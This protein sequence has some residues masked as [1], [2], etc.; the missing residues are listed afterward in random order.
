MNKI[1]VD[2]NSITGLI[3][4]MHGV[5]QPPMTGITCSLF[6]YLKEAG[7]PYS[8]LH[9]T[10]G[11]MGS[12]LYVDIP[13]IFRDFDADENDPN[14]YSFAFTDKIIEGLM[15]NKCEPFFRLGVTIENYWE[16]QS[17]RVFPPADFK[18]WARVCEHI[19]RHYNEGWANGYRYG[20]TYW[21]IWNE[22]EG[23]ACWRGTQEEYFRLYEI[24]S[25]HLKNCFGDSIKVGGYASCGFYAI[26]KNPDINNIG[27]D[28][29]VPTEWYLKYFYDFLKYITSEEHKSPL[30][31]F[32][33]HTYA[34]VHD[35][36]KYAEYSHKILC[37]YG[38][39]NIEEIIDEWNPCHDMIKKKTGYAAAQNLAMLLAMQK[40]SVSMMN[41]YDAR[42]GYS[43]FSGMFNPDTGTP[44][45]TY[46]AFMSFNRLY[47]LKNEVKTYSDNDNIF[48]GAATD[49]N[50]KVILLSNINDKAMTVEFDIKGAEVKDEDIF[51]I[52]EE[53]VYSRTGKHIT[54]KKLEIPA[55][56]CVEI[57]F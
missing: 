37:D 42:I 53:Y 27:L 10:G 32:S 45:P 26:D 51:M 11:A 18:K 57:S 15:E 17:F 1:S 4:P 34:D 39:E 35:V 49:G 5:G 33:W 47:R 40:T 31:F 52:N 55:F 36:V 21:E 14:S 8:R 13:N 23:E 41:F 7:I 20:I 29:T 22:P 46:F 6:H 54:D 48:V 44:Y 12:G 25:N 16:L 50:K 56:T 30:D 43:I 38:F 2:F 3:K 24:T 19:I 28:V 9:D